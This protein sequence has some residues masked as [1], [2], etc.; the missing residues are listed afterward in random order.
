MVDHFDTAVGQLIQTKLRQKGFRNCM[1]AANALFADAGQVI[2]L[3]KSTCY[4]Y[5]NSYAAGNFY[6]GTARSPPMSRPL[7]LYRL[8]VF[9]QWLEVPPDDELIA[10]IKN[11]YQ[12]FS[13]PL[14]YPLKSVERERLSSVHLAGNRS[15]VK[16]NLDVLSLEERVRLLEPSHK[17]VVGQ[18]VDA[19]LRTYEQNTQAN[20]RI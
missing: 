11:L 16:P 2:G 1:Q 12:D 15:L 14:S 9:L 6:M 4:G 5:V 19:F 3:A 20:R 18:V 8:S 7:M 10:G 13:Y 17:Q